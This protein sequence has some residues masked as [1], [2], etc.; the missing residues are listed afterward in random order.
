MDEPS[1]DDLRREAKRLLAENEELPPTLREELS[2]L[3]EDLDVAVEGDE[4]AG[5]QVR[6]RRLR[7]KMPQRT[8]RTRFDLEKAPAA[9]TSAV[10]TGSRLLIAEGG[11]RFA[12]QRGEERFV[13]DREAPVGLVVV[14]PGESQG[15]RPLWRYS[16]G[17]TAGMDAGLTEENWSQRLA[18]ASDNDGEPLPRAARTLTREQAG[19][20]FRAMEDGELKKA[21]G[22]EYD[23]QAGAALGE[24]VL[25]RFRTRLLSDRTVLTEVPPKIDGPLAWDGTDLVLSRAPAV[26]SKIP[27]DRCCKLHK[28]VRLALEDEPGS[29]YLHQALALHRL[30]QSRMERFDV[31]LATPT[32]S[33]KTLAFLP[34]V[35][36][37]LCANDGKALFLYPLRALCNDQI[38]K[39]RAFLSRMDCDPDRL[40]RFYGDDPVPDEAPW[41]MAATPDKLNHHLDKPIIQ[42]FLSELRW[43]VIDEAHSYKGC[44]GINV[45]LFLRRLLSFAKPECRLVLSSATLDN[46]VSF[47]RA[48]TGRKRFRVLSGSSA[49]RHARHF[50]LAAPGARKPLRS[51]VDEA[52]E[53]TT[54][55]LV[56]VLGRTDAQRRAVELAGPERDERVFAYH[57]GVPAES[58]KLARLRT[59]GTCAVAVTTSSL[60]AGI[61]LPDVPRLAICGFPRSR[62]SFLQMAGRAGRQGPGHIVFIPANTPADEYFG[63]RE[64]YRELVEGDAEPIYLNPRNLTLLR[65]HAERLAVEM[66]PGVATINVAITLLGDDPPPGVQAE[67]QEAARIGATAAQRPCPPDLRAIP[68]VPHVVLLRRGDRL[69]G[70]VPIRRKD[71]DE[72]DQFLEQPTQENARKEW[73]PLNV[74][75]RDG[76]YFRVEEWRKGLWNDDSGDMGR[77]VEA[78]FIWAEEVTN[79]LVSAEEIRRALAER[80]QLPAGMERVHFHQAILRTTGRILSNHDVCHARRFTAVSGR[81]DVSVAVRAS[82]LRYDLVSEFRCPRWANFLRGQKSRAEKSAKIEWFAEGKLIVKPHLGGGQDASRMLAFET[83]SEPGLPGKHYRVVRRVPAGDVLRI[84]LEE[85]RFIHSETKPCSCG[86]ALVPEFGWRSSIEDSPAAWRESPGDFLADR[87]FPSDLAEVAFPLATPGAVLGLA[88]ALLKVMPQVMFIDPGDVGAALVRKPE[89]GVCLLLYDLVE[90][91][92]GICA[93][94]PSKLHELLSAAERQLERSQ[95][96]QHCE[97]AGCF[98]CLLPSQNLDWPAPEDGQPSPEV[99]PRPAQALAELRVNADGGNPP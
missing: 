42:H 30:Q 46:T 69:L 12:L 76:R 56:F 10:P 21:T 95:R 44:F 39:I 78:V 75:M 22:D 16:S 36:T 92:A 90:G 74:A 96:C 60:E 48:L 59:P 83:A 7:G 84:E 63:Q 64:P 1:L 67:V 13:A 97:G 80:R 28:D 52:K 62:S 51:L 15:A 43:V 17:N 19:E 99:P 57:S 86:A 38:G 23:G 72:H 82:R 18:L 14:W 49:P 34:G 98:G 68:G 40:R 45:A 77:T 2:R 35:L 87:T 66:A 5:F 54:K 81:G 61:D 33:G 6:L 9:C 91:G 71:A 24:E 89:G 53:E 26:G 50:Y 47:A 25:R 3:D 70:M 37:D 73:A 41:L 27:L 79:R 20:L 11:S 29:L 55:G 88:S 58:E 65:A 31:I 85:H 4:L 8:A 93:A 32:A 94:V